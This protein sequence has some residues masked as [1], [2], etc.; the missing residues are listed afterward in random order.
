[1]VH[2]MQN[3][4]KLRRNLEET[5]KKL[6]SNSEEALPLEVLNKKTEEQLI[7]GELL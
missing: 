3:W 5:Q 7:R 1:M 4:K 2:I 6:R